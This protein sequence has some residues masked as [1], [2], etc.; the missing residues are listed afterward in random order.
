MTL[1]TLCLTMLFAVL[2]VCA[3]RERRQFPK[4]DD[5]RAVPVVIAA[6]AGLVCAVGVGWMVSNIEVLIFMQ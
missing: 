3:W 4:G 2:A 1:V 5:E 6:Y